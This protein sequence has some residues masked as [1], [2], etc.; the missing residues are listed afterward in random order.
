ML[1]SVLHINYYEN[2]PD[3]NFRNIYPT[4]FQNTHSDCPIL[5]QIC[6]LESVFRN[7]LSILQNIYEFHSPD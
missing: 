2:L 4:L 5:C 1:R 7:T 3:Q 6:T